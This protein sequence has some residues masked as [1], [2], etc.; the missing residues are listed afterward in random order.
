LEELRKIRR[1]LR[2]AGVLA[3]IQTGHL[4]IYP[5]LPD[6]HEEK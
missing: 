2:L 4:R 1:I 5:F 3:D 6:E